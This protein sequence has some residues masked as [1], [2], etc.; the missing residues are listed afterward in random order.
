M[1]KL[2]FLC[3]LLLV[4]ASIVFAQKTVTGKVTDEKDG[5]PL[6][7]VTV[8]VKGKGIGT[9]TAAD[10]TFKINLPADA[11]TLVF[12]SLNYSSVEINVGSRTSINVSLTSKDKNLQEV[13]VTGYQIRKKR[14]EGGAISSVKGKEIANLPNT[15]VDRALQGRAA[16]V[17]VQAN[18]G[19]PGGAINVRIRGTG[20]YLA[21]NQPLYI[22]DGVQLKP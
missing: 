18:N 17:L 14:D 1:K 21:G 7:G 2:F 9:A 6:M 12:S 5:S 11:K 20:S 3:C 8:I 4:S 16:G 10:G 13:V 15:S 19:I 22:V